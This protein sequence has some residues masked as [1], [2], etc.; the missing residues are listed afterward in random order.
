MMSADKANLDLVPTP[1]EGIELVELEGEG[2]LY[3]P[4]TM[5]MV[6]LND[7]ASIIWRLCDG[8]RKVADIIDALADAFPEAI[9]EVSLDVPEMIELLACEG[10]VELRNL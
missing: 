9:N 10:A 7:S 1:Q 6:Y 5:K 4:E 3:C 2:V 8:L